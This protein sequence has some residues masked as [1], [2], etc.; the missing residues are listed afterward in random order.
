ML[1]MPEK[2]KE[3]PPA[4]VCNG[5][6]KKIRTAP[7]CLDVLDY[8]TIP[9]SLPCIYRVGENTID[10][11]NVVDAYGQVVSKDDTT[12]TY[13][14]VDDPDHEYKVAC[15]EDIRITPVPPAM[16]QNVEGSDFVSYETISEIFKEYLDGEEDDYIRLV[17][18]NDWRRYDKYYMDRV[19][20]I[21]YVWGTGD[22][23]FE[24]TIVHWE[25]P[26]HYMI[27]VDG[28]PD[29]EG[30]DT[31]ERFF[32]IVVWLGDAINEHMSCRVFQFIYTYGALRGGDKYMDLEAVGGPKMNVKTLEDVGA[33]ISYFPDRWAR[34]ECPQFTIGSTITVPR[35]GTS[36]HGGSIIGG[37]VADVYG[38]VTA[39]GPEARTISYVH[40][41]LAIQ[42]PINKVKRTPV[43]PPDVVMMGFSE[44]SLEKEYN[45]VHPEFKLGRD[46]EDSS[47]YHIT[48]ARTDESKSS[49]STFTIVYSGQPQYYKIYINYLRRLDGCR[50]SGSAVL[51][52]IVWVGN[53]INE[54]I[55]WKL[56]QFLF[57]IDG[58]TLDFD[59]PPEIGFPNTISVSLRDLCLLAYGE[60]WYN[61]RGFRG[62][63]YESE[64]DHNRKLVE[65]TVVPE[66]VRALV[67][68]DIN[69]GRPTG[70]TVGKLF[71]VLYEDMRKW[72][73]LIPDQAAY[74][75]VKGVAQILEK[76]K[77]FLQEELKYND[78]EL[79]Y[80][81]RFPSDPERYTH[82]TGRDM[83][84]R[85]QL[86]WPIES[87]AKPAEP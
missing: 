60:S 18:S 24:F 30:Y 6:H 10:I 11:K 53:Y 68:P 82:P 66:D 47:V 62:L 14:P 39:I 38:I 34:G 5:C 67:W 22:T 56:V 75:K 61:K 3:G 65:T 33:L 12:I 45:F 43:P 58:S 16:T 77:Y 35:T 37:T 81:L 79:V 64:V 32:R 20:G 41:D 15:T 72:P 1:R 51:N 7:A 84:R 52:S 83:R 28:P 26:R 50:G 17:V 59:V 36:G 29:E 4:N 70:M 2:R 85:R 54:R 76:M 73:R 78:M 31:W 44:S 42:V 27:H 80:F 55:G 13:V 25:H 86:K 71:T 63:Q 49:V 74:D 69:G 87:S 48:C 46:E 21:D 9:R 57:L 23:E 19:Y 40:A 8:I